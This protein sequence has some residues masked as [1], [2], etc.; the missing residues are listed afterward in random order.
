MTALATM[1][2]IAERVQR[3][4]A[5]KQPWMSAA[6]RRELAFLGEDEHRQQVRHRESH[7]DGQ[8][9]GFARGLDLRHG[10]ATGLETLLPGVKVRVLGPPDLTQTEA[11]KKQRSTRSQRVLATGRGRGANRASVGSR[12]ADG[13]TRPHIL[14]PI[15]ARWFRDRLQSISGERCCEIVRQ[16]DHQ[17]NNTSLILLF[18]VGTKK[19]LFP[20]DAQ[21]ENWSYALVDAPN[22]KATGTLLEGVDVYKVGHHGSRN[23]TP[24]S[25]SGRG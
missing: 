6:V 11:I 17:M 22:A 21:I 8:G 25:C 13:A 14:L 15:E 4:A 19:L 16:L 2:G 7:R 10:D 5:S 12:A 3:L 9:E 24:K 18:E 1:N 23:A 20:G